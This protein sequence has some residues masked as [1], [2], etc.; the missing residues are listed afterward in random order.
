MDSKTLKTLEFDK[1]LLRLAE[2]ARNDGAKE[3]ALALMPSSKYNA[4]VQTLDETDAVVTLLLKYGT[5][6]QVS[7]ASPEE[8]LKRLAVGGGLSMAELLN[9]ARILK[10]ARLMKRYTEEQTG[11][12]Y[13]Y[14]EELCP[15]KRLEERITSSIISESEMADG[16]GT[17]LAAVRRKM[18]NASAKIRETLD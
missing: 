11:V 1:I 5:P 14:I 9:I 13:G 18:R 16:A 8:A 7:F 6:E 15:E 4:V 17:E 10:G 3:K 2:L 12:L